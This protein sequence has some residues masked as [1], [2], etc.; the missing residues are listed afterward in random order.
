MAT[1]IAGLVWWL[2]HAQHVAKR[3]APLTVIGP[4]GVEARFTAAAEA[5]FPGSTGVPRSYELNFLELVAR[6]SRSMSGA[7]A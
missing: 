2:I 6:G 4:A 7:C 3:T 5:L 1:T